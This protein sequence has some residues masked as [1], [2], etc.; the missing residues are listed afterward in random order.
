MRNDAPTDDALEQQADDL[1]RATHS[2]GKRYG[3]YT[4]TQ[5]QRQA[6]DHGECQLDENRTSSM[7][8]TTLNGSLWRIVNTTLESNHC[9]PMTVTC[10]KMWME[11][12]TLKE[13]GATDTINISQSTVHRRIKSALELMKTAEAASVVEVLLE[14]FL[15]QRSMFVRRR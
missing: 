7:N 12:Y 8:T 14:T 5:I 13:I 10:V 6:R 4:D 2:L 11:G 9:K 15:I 1:L 3:I